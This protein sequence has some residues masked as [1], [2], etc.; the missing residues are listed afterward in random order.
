MHLS[1]N[2]LRPSWWKQA[3][4]RTLPTATARTPGL[5]TIRDRNRNPAKSRQQKS[6]KDN[7]TSESW[8]PERLNAFQ[9]YHLQPNRKAWARR[10]KL[11]LV[12]SDKS[13]N[14]WRQPWTTQTQSRSTVQPRERSQ[15]LRADTGDPR[16]ANQESRPRRARSKTRRKSWTAVTTSTL[17]RPPSKMHR[18]WRLATGRTLGQGRQARDPTVDSLT[19]SKDTHIEQIFSPRQTKTRKRE[20]ER[21]RERDRHDRR[22]QLFVFS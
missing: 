3:G 10:A 6:L 16:S 18:R 22:Y 2:T 13:N 17:E 12:A 11:A 15:S 1:E 20:K 14:V 4:V 19:E 9:W 8:R 21:E 7:S 5:E